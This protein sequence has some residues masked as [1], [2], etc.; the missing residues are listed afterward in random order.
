MVRLESETTNTT[1]EGLS[2]RDAVGRGLPGQGSDRWWLVSGPVR[3]GLFSAF[4]LEDM[5]RQPV[6]GRLAQES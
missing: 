3:I 4:D 6:S 2:L 1:R 5:A